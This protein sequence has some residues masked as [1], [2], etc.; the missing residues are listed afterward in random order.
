MNQA[1]TPYR[2][3]CHFMDHSRI[4]Y[5]KRCLFMDQAS[6]PLLSTVPLVICFSLVIRV[7]LLSSGCSYGVY[8]GPGPGPG[9]LAMDGIFV[10]KRIPEN[11]TCPKV[12][13]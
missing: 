7:S 12:T 5:R 10:Q 8:A 13:I 4:P 11:L 1:R 6:L 9:P 2:R 3:R